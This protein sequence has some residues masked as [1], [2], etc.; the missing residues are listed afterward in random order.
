LGKG[1][2]I[3]VIVPNAVLRFA[4]QKNHGFERRG[5]EG[6]QKTGGRVF[7]LASRSLPGVSPVASYSHLKPGSINLFFCFFNVKLFI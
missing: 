7:S 5:M 1:R 3:L 6:W 2:I 4:R